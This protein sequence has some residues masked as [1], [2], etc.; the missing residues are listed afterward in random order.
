MFLHLSVETSLRYKRRK[1][2]KW[3]QRHQ[4]L[5]PSGNDGKE[6]ACN[7]GDLGSIPGWEDPP[8]EGKGCQLRHSGLENSMDCMVHGVAKSQTWLSNFTFT[9]FLVMKGYQKGKVCGRTNI[10]RPCIVSS[11]WRE[12]FN[13]DVLVMLNRELCGYVHGSVCGGW[14]LIKY[15]DIPKMQEVQK[16]KLRTKF[17][18]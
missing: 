15:R 3:H 16:S 14:K 2:K 10:P 13:T 5:L 1:K 4:L 7:V 9:F 11:R 8:G 18:S 17:F 6:S 12:L